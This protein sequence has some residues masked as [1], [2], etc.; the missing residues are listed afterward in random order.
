MYVCKCVCVCGVD[1]CARNKLSLCMSNQDFMARVYTI[2]WS[3]LL[4]LHEYLWKNI[5]W[6]CLKIVLWINFFFPNS[7]R[8][9]RFDAPNNKIKREIRMLNCSIDIECHN[10]WECC[11]KIHT[12][13]VCIDTYVWLWASSPNRCACMCL[14]IRVHEYIHVRVCVY[15]FAEVTNSI[16]LLPNLRIIQY[17]YWFWHCAVVSSTSFLLP[18]H[19]Q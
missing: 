2:F 19:T 12:P 14:Y 13:P 15:A 3:V 5:H 7:N 18:Q 10:R 17:Q 8:I 9:F 4:F 6:R 16:A 11:Y 1:K